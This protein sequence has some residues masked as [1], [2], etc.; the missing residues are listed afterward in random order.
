MKRFITCAAVITTVLLLITGCASPQ[1]TPTP[2]KMDTT[3]APSAMP[4][5]EEQGPPSPEPSASTANILPASYYSTT[6]EI[7]PEL[8]MKLFSFGEDME[9]WNTAFM[10]KTTADLDG[11]GKDETIELIPGQLSKD[12]NQDNGYHFCSSI[13]VKINDKQITV[14]TPEARTILVSEEGINAEITDIDE[15]DGKKEILLQDDAEDWTVSCIVTYNGDTIN[16][17]PWA[18]SYI[19]ANGSGYFIAYDWLGNVKLAGHE[20]MGI[21][22]LKKLSPDRSSVVNVQAKYFRTEFTCLPPLDES[23]TIATSQWDQSLAKAPGGKEDHLV[24]KGTEVLLGFYDTSGWMQV[25]AK[26]GTVLGWLDCRK[27]DWDTYTDGLYYPEN[28]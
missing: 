7:P 6:D 13:V 14:N 20:G 5:P 26:D 25:L 9:K 18:E 11:C 10:G 28:D 27:V 12:R 1:A 24:P 17:L 8:E 4:T 15:K 16:Q 23:I 21:Q 22:R 19:I 2:A 3:A